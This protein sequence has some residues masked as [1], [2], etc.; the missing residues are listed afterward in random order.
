M[1]VFSK[2]F[3]G[4]VAVSIFNRSSRRAWPERQRVGR[5]FLATFDPRSYLRNPFKE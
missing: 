1:V 4:M 3:A 2:L 5:F